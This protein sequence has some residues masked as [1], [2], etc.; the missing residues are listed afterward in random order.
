MA[1]TEIITNTAASPNET[2]GGDGG[3]N[4]SDKSDLGVGIGIGIFP[5]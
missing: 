4:R 1:T 3:L 2:P 5:R